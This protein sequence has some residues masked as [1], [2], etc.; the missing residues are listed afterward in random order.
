MLQV[1]DLQ[2]V[3]RVLLTLHGIMRR[4]TQASV[5]SVQWHISIRKRKNN[6]SCQ[7]QSSNS[8]SNLSG[9]WGVDL[10]A[11]SEFGYHLLFVVLLA[12]LFAA[13]LQVCSPILLDF[14]LFWEIRSLVE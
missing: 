7:L 13:F 2:I 4:N 1:V 14:P 10:Q 12:G 3:L 8:P 9:N 11:G 6:G 5:L